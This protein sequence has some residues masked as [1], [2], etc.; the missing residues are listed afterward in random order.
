MRYALT[1]HAPTPLAPQYCSPPL[2]PPLRHVPTPPASQYHPAQQRVRRH[3]A[4]VHPLGPLVPPLLAAQSKTAPPSRVLAESTAE[5]SEEDEVGEAAGWGDIAAVQSHGG[6][7]GRDGTGGSSPVAALDAVV[8]RTGGSATSG[9]SEEDER[10]ETEDSASKQEEEETA[11]EH[12][13]VVVTR[14]PDAKPK[15]LPPKKRKFE[16]ASEDEGRDEPSDGSESN[17]AAVERALRMTEREATGGR[18]MPGD[19]HELHA[20]AERSR[21]TRR[22]LRGTAGYEHL[23]HCQQQ[24]QHSTSHP[25][26]SMSNREHHP[27]PKMGHYTPPYHG[28][29]ACQQYHHPE[30]VARHGMHRGGAAPEAAPSSNAA[31][32]VN[33]PPHVVSNPADLRRRG[34]RPRVCTNC[35][36][37]VCHISASDRTG[38]LWSS[39]AEHLVLPLRLD[40]RKRRTTISNRTLA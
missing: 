15:K 7:N 25:P 38:V 2:Y 20:L 10:Q 8:E 5:R 28:G 21:N 34:P 35:C 31:A 18:G 26:H 23:Y 12:E 27:A 13:R 16:S 3:R 37:F 22:L 1:R 9:V 29:H 11:G 17:S 14:V 6:G 24:Q 40:E 30:A 36:C 32:A 4:H 19:R 33:V 39:C